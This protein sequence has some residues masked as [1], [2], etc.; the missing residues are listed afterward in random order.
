MAPAVEAQP[1]AFE[2]AWE[3]EVE[4][5]FGRG[6]ERHADR[7]QATLT[8]RSDGRWALAFAWRGATWGGVVPCAAGASVEFGAPPV[9]LGPLSAERAT[10]T[11]IPLGDPADPLGFVV[12]YEAR[13]S[14]V[15]PVVIFRGV[16]VRA[17]P[18][19]P[20]GGR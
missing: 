12:A 6:R 17:T 2:F 11:F 15:G 1:R 10:C 3:S 13:V 4:L 19:R 9:P 8:A 20:S 14:N 5:A 18:L 16:G 7:G